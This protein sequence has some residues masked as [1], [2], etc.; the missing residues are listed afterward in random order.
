MT[1]APLI[2]SCPFGN[3]LHCPGT[4]RTQGT[5]TWERRGGLPWKL[6]RIARTL[7]YQWR[8]QSWRNK[9]GLPNSGLRKFLQGE[10]TLDESI[11]S[12]YGFTGE[13]WCKLT[14]TALE[15]TPCLVELNLSC[16]NVEHRQFIDDFLPA[17]NMYPPRIIAKLPPLD[18]M[19]MAKAL[20]G[21]GV[22]TFHCCNTLGTPDG[23]LSGPVLKPY[24][25]LVIR[26][27]RERFGTET[28]I[29][30]GGGIATPADIADYAQAGANHVAIGS[31]LLNPLSWR[32]IP[33]LLSVA[34]A[35]LK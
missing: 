32:R 13:E 24:S 25:L 16:P 19:P 18:W 20:Y 21:V 10:P 9:L 8:M 33:H 31:I 12:I 1:L 14:R 11:I 28:R 4:A 30:G 2:I 5:F 26:A 7:R 6:W 27:L 23:G 17:A 3:Y 22:R 34:S 29:I 35:L 15:Q